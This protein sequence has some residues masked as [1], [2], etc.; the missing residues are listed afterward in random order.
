MA[1]ENSEKNYSKIHSVNLDPA[2]KSARIEILEFKDQTTRNNMTKHDTFLSN[3][4]AS[5]LSDTDYESI[6]KILYKYVKTI[7]PYDTMTDV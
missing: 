2:S 5:E 1:L 3:V 6:M 7:D 4:V